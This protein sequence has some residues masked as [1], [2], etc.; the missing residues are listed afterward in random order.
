VNK[1]PKQEK[2][3][4]QDKSQPKDKQPKKKEETVEVEV[5]AVLECES[6]PYRR[7]MGL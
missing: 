1:K 5:P 4:K 7:L 2:Q 3:D 6:K